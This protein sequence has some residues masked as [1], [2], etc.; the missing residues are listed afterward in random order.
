MA[1]YEKQASLLGMAMGPGASGEPTRVE[2]F[3]RL[4]LLAHCLPRSREKP[5]PQ[6]ETPESHLSPP[7]VVWQGLLK[8]RPSGGPFYLGLALAHLLQRL[9]QKGGHLGLAVP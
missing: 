2:Q 8:G 3:L 6:P 1:R 5:H 9:A 4:A 7:L